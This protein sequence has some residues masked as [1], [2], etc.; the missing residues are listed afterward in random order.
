MS[1]ATLP[2]SLVCN[3]AP[4]SLAQRLGDSRRPQV[5][6]DVVSEGNA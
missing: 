6:H 5:E 3:L 4:Q 1:S 2:G